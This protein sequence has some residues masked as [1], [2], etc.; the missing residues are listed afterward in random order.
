MCVSI[1]IQKNT[2]TDS[3]RFAAL[4]SWISDSDSKLAAM[5]QSWLFSDIQE[6]EYNVRW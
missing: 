6:R 3:K 1:D 5:I 4:C 2:K